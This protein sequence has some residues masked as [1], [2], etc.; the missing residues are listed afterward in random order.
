MITKILMIRRVIGRIIVQI[1]AT[2]IKFSIIKSDQ[3]LPRKELILKR[4]LVVVL[5][6]V[7]LLTAPECQVNTM[8]TV[9]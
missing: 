4:V 1:I 8:P 6:E 2:E 3:M 5:L 9:G 7:I